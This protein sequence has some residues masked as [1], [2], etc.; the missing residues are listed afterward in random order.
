M[1][2]FPSSAQPERDHSTEGG[3]ELS[4]A[5]RK[6]GRRESIEVPTAVQTDTGPGR[7]TSWLTQ[8][9]SYLDASICCCPL[10]WLSTAMGTFFGRIV[11]G[12]G[13]VSSSTPL[14]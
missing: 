13:R 5:G 7:E 8:E 3:R 1:A 10:V 12:S 2:Y 4:R 14:R 9:E 11:A 6:H